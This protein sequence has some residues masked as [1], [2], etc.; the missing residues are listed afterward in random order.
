MISTETLGGALRCIFLF[1]SS[2]SDCTCFES[3]LDF[4]DDAGAVVDDV[5]EEVDVDVEIVSPPFRGSADKFR[6]NSS[7][8]YSGS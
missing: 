8:A 4:V 3:G 7:S 2:G 6:P 1:L 5:E